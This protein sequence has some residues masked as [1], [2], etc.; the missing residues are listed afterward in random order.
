MAGYRVN[1]SFNL[2]LNVQNLTDRIY[3]NTA[4][5]THYANIAPGRSVT[6]TGN[7]SF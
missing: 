6:L 7:F 3:Y 4:Y 1:K 5:S 2:Q